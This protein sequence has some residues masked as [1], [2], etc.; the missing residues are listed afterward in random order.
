MRKV[1]A[2]QRQGKAGEKG[3]EFSEVMALGSLGKDE[4][5][6][7]SVLKGKRF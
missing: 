2:L 7:I 3:G 4:V 1:S 6:I 5:S